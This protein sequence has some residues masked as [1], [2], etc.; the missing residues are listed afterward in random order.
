MEIGLLI[1]FWYGVLHAFA[2]DHLTA[3]ANFSIGK[4]P[5]RAMLITMAFAFGHGIMLFAF[6]E[7]LDYFVVSESV[8]GYGDLI[9]SSVIIGMGIYL[10]YMVQRDK[11]HLRR[12]DHNGKEHIHVWFGDHHEHQSSA[13]AASAFTIGVLMGIGGV[14]GM[15]VT[16]GMLEGQSVEL[17][18]VLAFVAG[19]TLIFA[20]FG[21]IVSLINKNVLTSQKNVR[22]LFTAAGTLSLVVGTNMLV[23]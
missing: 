16:L 10:L 3:I 1:I 11:I 21:V 20:V 4:R 2:P 19:V 14:R 22:R 5:K 7:I 15:L 18:I 13:D 9:A 17:S 12:H 6:A 8:M 23:G